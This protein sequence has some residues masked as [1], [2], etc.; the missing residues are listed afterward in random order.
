MRRLALLL[1]LFTG[2]LLTTAV[3]GAP[4]PDFEASYK[5]EQHSLRIGTATI[6]LRTDE[7]GRY[8]YEFRSQP[9]GWVSWLVNNQL[10]ESSR[11]ETTTGGI[12]PNKYH[13]QR[14]G[15]RQRSQPVV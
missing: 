9:T 1:L 11:G 12:R 14:S 13:Y 7:Q 15:G 3:P 10:Q 8:L 4:L 2:V 6:A 5:L